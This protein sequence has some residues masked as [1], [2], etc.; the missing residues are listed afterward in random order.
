MQEATDIVLTCNLAQA[1][2][3]EAQMV[4]VPS[5]DQMTRD[6]EGGKGPE[7]IPH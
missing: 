1:G 6:E 3:T 2:M 4:S 5:L 7:S